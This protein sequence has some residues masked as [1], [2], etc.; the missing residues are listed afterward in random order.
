MVARVKTVAFQGIDCLEVDAEVQMGPG[1]PA[2]TVVGLPD[3]AVG[4]SR[5]RVRA[6]L[7]AIGLALPPG[8]IT[9]NLAPADLLKEGSHFDLPI[10]LGM[11]AEMGVL[12]GED[13]APYSVLGELGLDGRINAVAGVRPAAIAAASAGRGLICPQAQGSEA[14]WAGEIEVLAPASIIALVN[15]FKGSQVLPRPR[16]EMQALAS[17][18]LDLADIKGQ[19]S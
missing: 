1:M 19:E 17:H 4:E 7:A 18:A 15:H 16:P 9:I 3:K 2:F 10:A 12:S 11:L 6:A 13:L 5:E 8:R 14:A